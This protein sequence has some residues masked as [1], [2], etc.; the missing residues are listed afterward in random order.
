MI[1]R[2]LISLFL[3]YVAC[4]SHKL[5]PLA[6]AAYTNLSDYSHG[7]PHTVRLL[8]KKTG[9]VFKKVKKETSPRETPEE[10]VW[11]GIE[12]GTSRKQAVGLSLSENHT[13]RPPD[14]LGR[15]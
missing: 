5:V 1:T 4:I 14:Q 11:P 10:R 6:S 13:T 8:L 15:C 3:F 7:R 12:P 9:T 2:T